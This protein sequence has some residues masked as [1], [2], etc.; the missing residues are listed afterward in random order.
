MDHKVSSVWRMTAIGA[1]GMATVLLLPA[2]G[3]AGGSG[4]ATDRPSSVAT[5]PTTAAPSAP[6]PSDTGGGSTSEESPAPTGPVDDGV[7]GLLQRAYLVLRDLGNRDLAHLA[8]LVHPDLGVTFSPYAYV[9][10]NAVTL[11][12]GRLATLALQ[13]TFVWGTFDGIGNPI[14]LSVADY[15]DRFV[16]HQDFARAPLIGIDHL[17]QTGNTLVN[18]DEAFPG[19]HFVEF[20]IPGVDPQYAGMD[21]A[22]LRLVFEQAGGQWMLVGVVGDRWTI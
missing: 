6:A 16:T 20:N 7:P 9:E 3:L 15:F 2:C 17:V 12:A 8:G 1:L 13:E 18:L 21:W 19:A 14:D 4:G 22:S 10:P 5:P 11:S